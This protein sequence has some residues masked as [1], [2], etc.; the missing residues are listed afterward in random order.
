MMRTTRLGFA[1]GRKAAGR[2]IVLAALIALAGVPG[3]GETQVGHA[4]PDFLPCKSGG[5]YGQN[6][7]LVTCVAERTRFPNHPRIVFARVVD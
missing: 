5:P 1:A 4:V 2:P 7:H 3:Q 6:V